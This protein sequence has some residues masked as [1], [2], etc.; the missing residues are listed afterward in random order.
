MKTILY[1]LRLWRGEV[2]R[3]WVYR[4][5]EQSERESGGGSMLWKRR[6]KSKSTR[7]GLS[8]L[9]GGCGV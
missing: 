6:G 3:Y 1:G 4:G 9:P 2:K 7:R 8:T 5:F